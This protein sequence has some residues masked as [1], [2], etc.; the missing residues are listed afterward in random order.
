[1]PGDSEPILETDDGALIDPEQVA[2]LLPDAPVAQVAREPVRHPDVALEQ[3]Q[4]QRRRQIHDD[5]IRFGKTENG[6][7]IAFTEWRD[8]CRPRIVGS[9]L[10]HRRIGDTE[11]DRHARGDEPGTVESESE[12]G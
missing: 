6:I 10:G 5:E 11:M 1:V 4:P 3:R 8:R 9:R 2:R 7:V 12:R